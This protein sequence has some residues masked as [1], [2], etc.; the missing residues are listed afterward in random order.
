MNKKI[1]IILSGAIFLIIL[2][3]SIVFANSINKDAQEI[4]ELN[5][6]D[7]VNIDDTYIKLDSKN[8]KSASSM[9]RED[10]IAKMKVANKYLE[11]FKLTD[12]KINT[13]DT[14]IEVY[15]NNLENIT[16]TVISNPD[17]IV[18]LNNDTGKLISYI[19]NKTNFEKNTLSKA[20]IESKA[21]EMLSNIA[22][23]NEY[24]LI[25]LEQFDEEIYRAK[26]AKTYGKYVNPGELVS[27]S[28]APQTSEVVT[29]AQKSVP[30]ANNEIKLSESDAKKI[31]EKYLEKSTA[32]EISSISLEIVQPNSNLAEP[33]PNGQVYKNATQTRLAYVCNFN[34]SSKTQIY[35]D[36][37]TGEAIGADM[38][39]GGDF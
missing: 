16:E 20:S 30:F 35:I 26:F 7:T 14:K 37:T 5:L 1:L 3:S 9:N 25:M 23:S 15:R 10:E 6:K 2:I 17:M 12:K 19:N 33:L 39:L 8:T 18:T 11:T 34:N 32:S 29:F 27:F 36:C 31:A 21:L 28:F 38:I 4:K 22:N 24:K 13:T